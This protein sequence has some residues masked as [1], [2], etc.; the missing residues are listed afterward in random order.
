MKCFITYT[1]TVLIALLNNM[2]SALGSTETTGDNIFH[3]S[4]T[5]QFNKKERYEWDDDFNNFK[6]QKKQ[7]RDTYRDPFWMETLSDSDNIEILEVNPKYVSAEE[8][9]TEDDDESYYTAN[10]ESGEGSVNEEFDY[11]S[12]ES[13]DGASSGWEYE[14]IEQHVESEEDEEA[15]LRAVEKVKECMQVDAE[16]PVESNLD[17]TVFEKPIDSLCSH[18][19]KAEGHSEKVAVAK[20]LL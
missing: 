10:S 4:E 6:N 3:S 8:E 1:I 14:L 17:F 12:S 11:E 13:D 5:S 19:R 7:E 9:Q 20:T 2:Q 16:L 15:Y 18:I